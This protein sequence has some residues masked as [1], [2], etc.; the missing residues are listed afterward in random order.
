MTAGAWAGTVIHTHMCQV[1][2]N[3]A[4][5]RWDKTRKMVR[6]IWQEYSDRQ[7]EL[8]VEMLGE[9]SAGGLNHKQLER[10]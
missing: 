6:D 1:C 4:Q 3:V 5:E 2:V 7:T 10:R 8:P 9:D